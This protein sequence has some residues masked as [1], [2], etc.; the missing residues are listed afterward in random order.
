MGRRALDGATALE[1]GLLTGLGAL[2]AVAVAVPASALLLR[3]LDPVPA[4][5]PT[6]LF[7]V[8]WSSV[9]AVL[10]G[11]VLVTAATALVVGR[12]ARA[13]DPGTVLRGAP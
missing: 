4:L 13:D 11:V 6:P 12:S 2:V 9:A 3:L 8:P 1:T 10:A 5:L 7:A